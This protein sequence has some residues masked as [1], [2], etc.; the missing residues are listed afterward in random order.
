MSIV[1]PSRQ[2]AEN[3]R[4]LHSALVEVLSDFDWEVI[5][6]D[7]SDDETPEVLAELFAADPRV[8]FLHRP[9]G[10]REGGLGGAVLAGF[11]LARSSVIVVMDA[12]LQHP[13]QAVP[14]LLR[15][16]LDGTADIAV[17]SR[18]T[19]AGSSEGL[20][21]PVRHLVSRG[22]RALVHAVFR[23][24]RVTSDPLGGF[25]ALDARI[26][27]GVVLRP[28]G[29]KILLEILVRAPWR[30]LAD[31]GYTFAPRVAGRSKSSLAEGRRFL[32]HVAGLRFGHEPSGRAA[33][34]VLIPRQRRAG[35]PAEPG[36]VGTT[37]QQAPRPAAGRPLEV[38]VITSEAPPVISGISTTVAELR[39]GLVER[40]HRVEVVSRRDFPRWMR[41]EIRLSA[42][43]FFWRPLR[44]HLR[45]F[46]VVNVH[47]PVP[48]MSEVFLLLSGRLRAERPAVV[49]THH[50]DLSIPGLQ[51]WCDVYNTL[52]RR[53]AHRSDAVVVSSA[54]YE[55]RMRAEHGAPVEVVPWGVETTGRVQSRS[56]RRHGVLRVLFVGQLRPYKGLHV[57]LD[58]IEGEPGIH[59]D[60]V[61]DG[62]M[63]S[64]LEAR[65]AQSGTANVTFHGR[66]PDD[67]LWRAY[68]DND[69]IVLP[70]TTTAEAYGLVLV[71]GMAAGCVPVASD[72]P[73]VREVASRTGVLV[74]P[75]DAPALRDAL[76]ELAGDP[77]ELARRSA[78]S[79][80]VGAG[81]SR[82][83]A[84]AYERIMLTA[85]L[86]R[87]GTTAGEAL[88][89][90][91]ASPAA[92][93]TQVRD[94]LGTD[95]VSLVVLAREGRRHTAGLRWTPDGVLARRVAEAPLAAHAAR[96][97]RA[98]HLH[99]DA[100][101]PIAV[102]LLMR[103][104]DMGTAV[105]LPLHRT[106]HTS[107]VL[108][109]SAPAAAPWLTVEAVERA[110][111]GQVR[112]TARTIDLT[113]VRG[114]DTGRTPGTGRVQAPV[115]QA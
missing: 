7:D 64:E 107:T 43:A 90:R 36:P 55:D 67:A 3:V 61:G 105:L 75:G 45:A 15:P 92:L 112:T 11:R 17:G 108:C 102:R 81:S 37:A 57:L 6:V 59:L 96:R 98:L 113:G 29:Y 103:R 66:L 34:G 71:E 104:H 62:A 97:G 28:E 23:R 76:L 24:T 79:A 19:G 12:D 58:A 86:G 100:T 20:D 47:G 39:R 53:I 22:C 42:F 82:A 99:P 8:R 85:V 56:P 5:F 68:A 94:A 16:V 21:G 1:V 87:H 91:W 26:L 10:S 63:R 27:R 50:S 32:Q 25:F 60:V 77:E 101:T 83:T 78:L 48:T 35:S 110:V 51:R 95:Q 38:L 80:T 2:E 44:R 41:R 65:V 73:G 69:V 18:Y 4:R 84:E 13:P 52:S 74:P 88:P 114:P 70:S 115:P 54:A 109:V 89:S 106:A 72:L 93:V 31:V 33:P 111:T 40:G 9:A 14:Q 30:R 46:D 49:Y